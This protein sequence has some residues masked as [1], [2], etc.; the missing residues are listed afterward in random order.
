MKARPAL[1]LFSFFLFFALSVAAQAPSAP[2]DAV[3]PIIGTAGGGN[4]FPGASLPFGMIQWSPDL[5]PR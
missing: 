3:N 5:K 1:I 4:T 2:Y